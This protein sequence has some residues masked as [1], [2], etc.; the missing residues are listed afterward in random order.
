MTLTLVLPKDLEAD[1]TAGAAREGV[2]VETYALRLL[3]ALRESHSRVQTG[4]ELVEY[5]RHEGVIGSR[6]DIADSQSHA[7]AIRDAA[8]R[9]GANDT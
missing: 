1:L 4:A 9:R 5:W 6:P 3:S 8:E 2:P 7:R